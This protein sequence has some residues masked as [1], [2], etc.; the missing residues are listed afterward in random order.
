MKKRN[1]FSVNIHKLNSEQRRQVFLVLIDADPSLPNEL[2]SEQ[3]CRLY[4]VLVAIDS[5]LT[6]PLLDASSAIRGIVNGQGRAFSSSQFLPLSRQ[7]K[8]KAKEVFEEFNEANPIFLVSEADFILR[9]WLTSY[10]NSMVGQEKKKKIANA[11]AK[12]HALLLPK[13]NIQPPVRRRNTSNVDIEKSIF[14]QDDTN[15]MIDHA[16]DSDALINTSN[17]D[18]DSESASQDN[19]DEIEYNS[20]TLTPAIKPTRRIRFPMQDVTNNDSSDSNNTQDSDNSASA[21]NA[22]SLLKDFKSSCSNKNQNINK[23]TLTSTKS[24]LKI[25]FSLLP[26]NPSLKRNLR[27]SA[28]KHID[29][30]HTTNTIESNTQDSSTSN[31]TGKKRKGELKIKET[32]A[33]ISKR[34]KTKTNK[35]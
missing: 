23:D 12:G 13:K 16:Q 14:D 33:G 25:I 26:K 17:E 29:I 10:C 2:N 24:S 27:S 11:R 28:Q 35:K 9:N 30:E 18:S 21:I 6:E 20:D 22:I 5:T 3:R 4:A 15:E 1:N 8:G 34:T 7:P 19:R 31:N 32:K